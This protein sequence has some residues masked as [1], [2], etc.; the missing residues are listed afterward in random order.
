M[1]KKEKQK[2][3]KATRNYYLNLLSLAPILLLIVSG[4]VVLRYH[5]GTGYEIRTMVL[6]GHTWL[7][8]HKIMAT[9][10]IP[11]IGMHLWFHRYWIKRIFTSKTKG[12]NH[13]MNLVLF[14]V[15][16]LCVL[17]ALI[18]WLLFNGKPEADLLREVHNK[19]GFAFIFFFIV[20]LLNH[21][22][23][24]L[25]MTR[26]LFIKTKTQKS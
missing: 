14:A 10:V 5:G 11:L 22:K 4:L 15:F 21:S 26:K 13:D 2:V 23:W 7:L 6:D 16:M 3:S 1:S 17:T 8:F 24:L 19:F 25:T 18:S 12:K 20:H 9:M